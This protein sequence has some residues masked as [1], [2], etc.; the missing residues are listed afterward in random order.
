[1]QTTLSMQDVR[2]G[3]RM[4][5]R[6]PGSTV[7][8]VLTLALAIGVNTA[9]FSVLN[10]ALLK[11]LPVRNPNELV[12]LTDPNA[13]MVLGGL[14][15]GERSLLTYPEFLQLRDRTTTMSD[16]CASQLTLERWPVRIGSSTSEQVR[17]RLVS[18]NYFS[19][20]GVQPA[21]G[22]FFTQQD[23]KGVGKDPYAVI[24]YD[25][26][27]RRFGGERT[28]LGTSVRLH[29]ASVVIIG[30]AANGFRG[31]TQGQEPGMWLPML[32]QPL[33]MPG[34]DGLRDTF[35]GSQDKLM[36][37]HAFGRRKAGVTTRQVQAEVNVLF[38]AILEA[39]YP[40]AIPGRSRTEV[41]NQHIR[42]KPVGTGAFH[43]R[44]E[45]AEQW[46]LLSALAALCLFAACANIA[47]LLL[48]RAAT[49][50]GEVAVRLSLGAARG[51]L[52]RQFLTESLLV[53]LLGGIVGIL[54]A[55]VISRALLRI[56]AEANDGFTIAPSIDWHVLGFSAGTTL[57][58][59]ILF[60]LAPALHAT[61]HSVNENLK[62]TGRNALASRK[63]SRFAI[64]LVILQV[65][66]SLFLAIGSGLFLRTLWNL[67]SVALGYPRDN[68][69]LVDVDSSNA[70]YQGVRAVSLF[71]ELATRVRDIP[72]VRAVTYSDRGLFSGFEG[73]FPIQVEGFVSR[74]EQDIGSTGDFVGPA[75]FSTVGIPILMGREIGPQDTADSPRVCVINE[76][77]A[78]RFF[79]HHNPLGRHVTTTAAQRLEVVGVAKDVRV[80][81]L[82]GTIDPKFYIAGGRSWLEV[83]TFGDPNRLVNVV[84]KAII[85]VDGELNIRSIRTLAQTLRIQ[86]AQ[87]RL[88]AQLATSFGILALVLA[89]TGIYGL[90]SYA[91]ARR[92]N[93]IGI[94][95]ALGADR[96]RITGMIL[97]ETASMIS[98]G[99]I[100]GVAVTAA[101]ARVFATQLYGPDSTGPRW[102]L[103]RYE[104]VESAIQL[105]GLTAMDPLT[106]GI[107]VG[108][109]CALG[110]IAAYLPALRAAR[111]D[112]VH[113]LRNE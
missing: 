57:L 96:S 18:E 17:G 78:K 86:N 26:W 3:L 44:N 29:H 13:S 98:L 38:R 95:L 7:V 68:L 71:R 111:V 42:V 12:M 83:R 63:R 100:A 60:G 88:I 106:I 51:R 31:E 55:Q 64:S 104:H 39:G 22:R 5:A 70:G 2:F 101:G 34:F 58:T 102:S 112:P 41:L 79:A 9:I 14:L 90:L 92:R 20:L 62:E 53:A 10:A 36:W 85:D 49:R 6:S 40:A 27:Q 46:T 24:S 4:L 94:R 11:L 109:L 74:N 54:I 105:S 25:Y 65:A 28:V 73:S 113:A 45:F 108:V 43:G 67:E 103:A 47:N 107:A 56:L 32:M 35:N 93:E 110:F 97:K 87:P 72:G 33:V 76:A 82:R 66:L 15:T 84:R 30:V 80:Q 61:R 81:S 77:F 1:M 16:L 8:T 23:A 21:L 48:A 99:V 37:L 69:L 19:A 50:A 59:G 89:A 75:Y 91:V 52:I